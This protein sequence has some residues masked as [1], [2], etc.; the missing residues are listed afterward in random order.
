MVNRV[1]RV[2]T[3]PLTFRPVGKASIRIGLILT[4]SLGDGCGTQEEGC[5][6]S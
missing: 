5:R 3:Y 6:D 2:S 4:S 1:Y